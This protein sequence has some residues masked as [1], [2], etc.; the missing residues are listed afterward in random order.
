MSY[1]TLFH[2]KKVYVEFMTRYQFVL[3]NIN[4]FQETI[5]IHTYISEK[6]KY[7]NAL[8]PQHIYLICPK[9]KI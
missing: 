1:N 7:L 8:Y 5:S 6:S 3:K 9:L 2:P 4:S